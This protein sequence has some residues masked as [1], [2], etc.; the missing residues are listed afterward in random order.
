M[1]GIEGCVD[2]HSRGG[3]HQY[4]GARGVLRGVQL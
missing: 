4:V 2:D 3:K 1:N